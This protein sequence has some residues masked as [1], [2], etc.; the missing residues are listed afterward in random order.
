MTLGPLLDRAGL[1]SG[2]IVRLVGAL[3]LTAVVIG[4]APS[5]MRRLWRGPVAAM[6]LGNR[7]FLKSDDFSP[8]QLRRLLVHEFVH[9]RQWQLAG[10]LR[11]LRRYLGD[12]VRGRLRGLDHQA[13]Y[14]RIRYET[15]ARHIADAV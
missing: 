1:D 7:V 3:D 12:Y 5:W 11:F 4:P 10:S 2:T 9:V 8:E 15:E 6:T 13:A 14:S